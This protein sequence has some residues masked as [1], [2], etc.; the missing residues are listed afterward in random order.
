MKKK[1]MSLLIGIILAS[2]LVAT[3][4]VSA[5]VVEG[6][7]DQ[8]AKTC[9]GGFLGFRPLFQGLTLKENSKCQIGKPVGGD[10][11]IS[12]F[13]W[14]IILNIM[15]DVSSAVG[16]IAIFFIIYGGYHFIRS[17]GDVN[18]VAKGKKTIKAAVIGLVIALL[19]T[20]IVNTILTVIG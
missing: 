19:E 14:T 1:M 8:V 10:E 3:R 15:A 6:V 20:V 18:Y 16:Y 4:P 12:R 7:R 5:A 17:T 13:V 11:L 9:E 2:G